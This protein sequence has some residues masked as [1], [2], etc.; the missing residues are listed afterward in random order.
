LSFSAINCNSL[1]LSSGTKKLQELKLYGITA[2]KTD[3]IFL[4]DTRLS[5]KNLVSSATDVSKKFLTNSHGQYE[6]FYNSSKNSRGTGILLKKCHNFSVLQRWDETSENCLLMQLQLDEGTLSIGSIY[7]PNEN[8]ANF[9]ETVKQKLIDWNSTFTALAGDWNCLFS[10]AARSNIDCIN[11]TN[12]PNPLNTN[13]VI[14]LCDSCNLTDP[15]RYVYPDRAEFTYSPRDINKKNRSRLDYFL[16]STNLLNLISDVSIKQIL[17]NNLFD[18]KAILLTLR[19]P[20]RQPKKKIFRIRN[21]LLD[22]DILQIRV[23]LAVAEAYLLHLEPGQLTREDIA[24][25]LRKVGELKGQSLLVPYPYR[26]WPEGYYA[27]ADIL[28]RAILMENFR[29]ETN[30]I[31]IPHL[32]VL[33]KNINC[34][35]FMETLLIAV[36][37]EIISF[38]S[39]FLKWKNS[40]INSLQNELKELK[41]NYADNFDRIEE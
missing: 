36:K 21:N 38:Q 18:H 11:M 10:L 41:K 2:L 1:N 33:E 28:N 40:T 7:G 20:V 34:L 17:Q 5:N 27:E 13:S 19:D 29:S 26:Y 24:T 4:S 31:G 3:V 25:K 23:E 14:N 12:L 9:F 35:L 37:N 6:F 30:N 22:V 8:N 32:F 15:F 16:I 39:H